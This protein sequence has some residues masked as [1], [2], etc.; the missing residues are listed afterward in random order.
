MNYTH[1]IRKEQYQIHALRSQELSTAAI[2]VYLECHLST[3]GLEQVCNANGQ[4]YGPVK[5]HTHMPRS[6]SDEVG[7]ADD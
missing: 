4:G 5:V 1:L 2:A 7:Q 3:I 6:A